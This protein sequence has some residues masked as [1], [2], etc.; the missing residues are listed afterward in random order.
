M[1]SRAAE[2]NLGYLQRVSKHAIVRWGEWMRWYPVLA[3][4]PAS[5]QVRGNQQ[6]EKHDHD[7]WVNW[8][9]SDPASVGLR[10][11]VEEPAIWIASDP[12]PSLWWTWE[13]Q[14]DVILQANPF[15][16]QLTQHHSWWKMWFGLDIHQAFVLGWAGTN[17]D[18][19]SLN[20]S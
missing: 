15:S 18:P 4:S 19:R 12:L 20:L 11:S 10:V 2:V 16:N 9:D 6:R 7:S 8:V 17:Q 14:Y 5:G 3:D 1:S 13:W